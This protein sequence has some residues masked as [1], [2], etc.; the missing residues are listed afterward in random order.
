MFGKVTITQ[1]IG[2]AE[3]MVQL[4]AAAITQRIGSISH[5]EKKPEPVYQPITARP[6]PA[7]PRWRSYL[8]PRV[9]P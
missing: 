9:A 3:P 8:R 2:G 7:E 1:T 6:E 5:P 4:D